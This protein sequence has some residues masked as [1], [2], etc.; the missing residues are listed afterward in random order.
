MLKPLIVT[1][2]LLL[3]AL[4]G[5]CSPARPANPAPT[6]I[7]I[8]G[9][10]D[11]DNTTILTACVPA[12]STGTIVIV[13]WASGEAEKAAAS[14]ARRFAQHAPRA[15]IVTIADPVTSAQDSARAAQAFDALR[16][17]GDLA[18]F[19]GG[20]QSRITARLLSPAHAPVLASLRAAALRPGVIIAGTSAG[21]AMMSDPMFTGGRSDAALAVAAIGAPSTTDGATDPD[22]PEGSPVIGPRLAPGVGLASA[23]IVDTHFSQRGR[24]GR[25]IAALEASATPLG[26]GLN[27]NRAARIEARTVTFLGGPAGTLLV[28][29]RELHRPHAG[30][31]DRL[32]AR[33]HLAADG[34]ALDRATLTLAPLPGSAWREV[35]RGTS[36]AP[37]K[38]GAGPWAKD[39][40]LHMLARL[41]AEPG[42]PQTTRGAR[43]A[44]TLRTDAR[45]RF[46]QGPGGELGAT[47]V[48]A[49]ITGVP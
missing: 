33:L 27:E 10:L 17:A 32:G 31:A 22:N 34:L 45:T 6:L 26:V 21:A 24:L 48:I 12:T 18:F 28:T 11:D 43:F 1:L 7:A 5:A 23:M 4:L 30:R 35:P 16:G 19:T 40:V 39:E 38:P 44:L 36:P 29:A 8:G 20:D 9:G 2:T 3:A 14:A 46:W 13:P 15:T 25:L 37:T 42:T 41:A 47:E 49:D